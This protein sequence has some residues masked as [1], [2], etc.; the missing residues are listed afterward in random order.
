MGTRELQRVVERV[1][2]VEFCDKQRTGSSVITFSV[3]ATPPIWDE[4]KGTFLG[5]GLFAAAPVLLPLLAGLGLGNAFSRVGLHVQVHRELEQVRQ[6]G[7][8]H[9]RVVEVK[10][11]QVDDERVG[12]LLEREPLESSLHHLA[13]LLALPLHLLALHVV[14][15]SLLQVRLALLR[16]CAPCAPSVSRWHTHNRGIERI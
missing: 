8:E 2:R 6:L 14:R 10:P 3:P 15:Q 7:S 12:Q 5:L 4:T 11:L 13:A 16:I 1:A 9:G